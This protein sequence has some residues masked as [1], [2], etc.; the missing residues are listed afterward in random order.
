VVARRIM[1]PT[2]LLRRSVSL[3][4]PQLAQDMIWEVGGGGGRGRVCVRHGVYMGYV[5]EW[6]GAVQLMYHAC[7]LV[8]H[9][10]QACLFEYLG[11]SGMNM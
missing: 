4:A 6:G 8:T 11:N 1:P 10:I 2:V 3:L 5:R 7:D 9:L